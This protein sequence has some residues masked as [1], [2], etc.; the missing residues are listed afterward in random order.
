[1]NVDSLE[2]AL[3]GLA[4]AGLALRVIVEQAAGVAVALEHECPVVEVAVGAEALCQPAAPGA[5]F[6]CG[7]VLRPGHDVLEAGKGAKA[8]RP[9]EPRAHEHVLVW[10]GKHGP[11]VEVAHGGVERHAGVVAPREGR[12]TY[13]EARRATDPLQ[14][15]EG[16]ALQLSLLTNLSDEH[17]VL[18]LLGEET[19]LPASALLRGNI[20][21]LG[22]FRVSERRTVLCSDLDIDGHDRLM[23]PCVALT[24][25]P[26]ANLRCG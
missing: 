21:H 12:N 25:P 19:D 10:E 17:P 20:G 3:E 7:T 4:P 8:V 16:V 26:P 5:L 1:M 15:G 13:E 14:G 9:G 11:S 22:Q 23:L 2:E 6:A 18:A 24:L